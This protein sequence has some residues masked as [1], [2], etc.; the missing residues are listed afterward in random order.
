MATSVYVY[1]SPPKLLLPDTIFRFKLKKNSTLNSEYLWG[2]FSSP[3][4]KKYIQ[5]FATG[6]AGSM[7][8]ISKGKLLSVTIPVP[9]ITMQQQFSNAIF[10]HYRLRK[11]WL[12][13]LRQSDYLFQSLLNQAFSYQ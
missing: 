5:S 7:P 1:E 3:S 4:F 12:E 8:N 11:H 6:T 10:K 13:S 9:P 2:L